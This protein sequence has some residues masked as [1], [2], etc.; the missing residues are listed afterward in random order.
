MSCRPISGPARD[1]RRSCRGRGRSH[2]C[3][4]PPS[5]STPTPSSRLTGGSRLSIPGHT[6]SRGCKPPTPMSC[7]PISV[8]AM[9]GRRSC[10]E[11]GRKLAPKPHWSRSIPTPSRP[12][13]EASRRSIRDHAGSPGTWQP[14]RT[15]SRQCSTPRG[16]GRRSCRSHSGTPTSGTT[17]I[18]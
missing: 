15:S 7:L 18:G 14:T 6:G 11:L 4:P 2:G 8:P 13:R 3:R 1:G 9:A 12:S 17:S 10:R 16:D 5:R